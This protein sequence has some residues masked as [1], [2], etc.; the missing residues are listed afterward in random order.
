TLVEQAGGSA[1]SISLNFGA[2][3]ASIGAH[4]VLTLA[5]SDTN[6]ALV[7]S[8]AT[9]ANGGTLNL[10][11]NR[12]GGGTDYLPAAVT[13]TG[14]TNVV[15]AAATVDAGNRTFTNQGS[16]NVTAAGAIG[17]PG[18]GLVNSSGTVANSGAIRIST[19]YTQGSGNLTGTPPVVS[20]AISYTGN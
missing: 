17:F 20:G 7:D 11:A 19:G 12:G 9:V 3:G 15:S 1:G 5:T 10:G 6:Y 2:G 8:T 18:S 13:H 4:G 16:L 14:T